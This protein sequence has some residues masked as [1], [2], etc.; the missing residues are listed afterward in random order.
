[1]PSVAALLVGV[2][3]E[4]AALSQLPFCDALRDPGRTRRAERGACGTRGVLGLT[5][6]WSLR[7]IGGWPCIGAPHCRNPW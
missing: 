5:S 2:T 4:G 6:P 1:M 3:V 7:Y